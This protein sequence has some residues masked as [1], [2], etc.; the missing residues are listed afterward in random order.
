VILHLFFK[1]FL[2][3]YPLFELSVLLS[4]LVK[5]VLVHQNDFLRVLHVALNLRVLQVPLASLSLGLANL[6]YDLSALSLVV[7]AHIASGFKLSL[8]HIDAIY[9]SLLL[10]IVGLLPPIELT[11]LPYVA[12][13]EVLVVIDHSLHYVAC[14]LLRLLGTLPRTRLAARHTLLASYRPGLA[15]NLAL[16]WVLRRMREMQVSPLYFVN[17][18][19]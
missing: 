16:V 11:Y 5:E 15:F 13:D 2:S 1:L 10:I 18:R 7:L 6:F 9:Q 4:Q 8:Q 3:F 19:G 12:F 14:V 17:F